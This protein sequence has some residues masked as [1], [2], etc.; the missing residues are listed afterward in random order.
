M[1]GVEPWIKNRLIYSEIQYESHDSHVN[2]VICLTIRF[3]VQIRLDNE[4]YRSAC[5]RYKHVVV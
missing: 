5:C 4:S 3:L 1:C 2:S